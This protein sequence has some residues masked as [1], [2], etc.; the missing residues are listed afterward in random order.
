[1]SPTSLEEALRYFQT[2][3]QTL[4]KSTMKL[5]D[6]LRAVNDLLVRSHPDEIAVSL[7][8]GSST[9]VTGRGSGADPIY[10]DTVIAFGIHN[11]GYRGDESDPLTEQLALGLMYAPDVDV[12]KWLPLVPLSGFGAPRLASRR[13]RV[14]A[15][16][17]LSQ[18]VSLL[19]EAMTKELR[20]VAA[21][22]SHAKKATVTPGDNVEKK[23]FIDRSST[24]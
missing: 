2:T 12:Y 15:G 22:A 16:Q 13:L 14:W 10:G 3:A 5:D 23:A 21:A 19:A 11:F 8:P 18:L 6:A 7:P 17:N 4:N 9:Y 24:S 1:M 20:E